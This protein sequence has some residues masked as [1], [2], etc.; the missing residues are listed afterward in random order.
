MDLEVLLS[1]SAVDGIATRSARTARTGV[2][3]STTSHIDKE[4]GP[5]FLG[6][7]LAYHRLLI[8]LP[9]SGTFIHPFEKGAREER[10]DHSTSILSAVIVVPLLLYRVLSKEIRTSSRVILFV[11]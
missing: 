4:H 10:C 9:A 1:Y 6:P 3:P 2:T 5:L 8:T 7:D 11:I